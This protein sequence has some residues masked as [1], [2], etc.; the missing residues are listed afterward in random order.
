[1]YDIVK[2]NMKDCIFQVLYEAIPTEAEARLL[3]KVALMERDSDEEIILI[4]PWSTNM[5]LNKDS[6]E[7]KIAMALALKYKATGMKKHA[8]SLTDYAKARRRRDG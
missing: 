2:I 6:D 8:F 3:V 7:C 4:L 5:T 1:M